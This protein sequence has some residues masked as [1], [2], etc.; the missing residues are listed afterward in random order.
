MDLFGVHMVELLVVLV[1]ALVVLGPAKTINMARGA[2]KMLGQMRRAM[3][4]LSQAVEE[5]EREIQRGASELDRRDAG[6]GWP[7]E[8]RR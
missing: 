5:Q 3:T 2:G 8:E 4:D 1:V 7:P 6:D